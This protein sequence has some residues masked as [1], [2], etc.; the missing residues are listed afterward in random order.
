MKRLGTVLLSLSLTASL[1]TVG[2]ASE[3]EEFSE[4][5]VFEAE[6]DLDFYN[7]SINDIIR[8][9][10]A[11]RYRYNLLLEAYEA[12]NGEY[13]E[14]SIPEEIPEVIPDGESGKEPGTAEA[15]ELTAAGDIFE[16]TLLS[17]RSE[18]GYK[19][20]G[21]TKNAQ[22]GCQIVYIEMDAKNISEEDKYFNWFNF[23]CYVDGYSTDVFDDASYGID[24]M[25]GDIRK[26]KHR[27]GTLPFEL[28]VDWEE[29]EINYEESY[30]GKLI[31][32]TVINGSE[33]FAEE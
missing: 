7:M 13:E 6:S 22:D 16:I 21:E 5:P 28:P 29:L 11:L 15:A 12:Q 1:F 33:L 10:Q 31:T 32:L 18:E 24:L 27:I 20:F 17:A 9:Y 8:E 26:G 30:N 25:T 3:T 19:Y 14:P 4:T 2:Y 23:D